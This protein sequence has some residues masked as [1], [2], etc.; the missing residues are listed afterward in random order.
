MTETPD[1]ADTQPIIETTP[2]GAPSL[3]AAL[4]TV[5]A[6]L[7]QLFAAVNQIGNIVNEIVNS[8]IM[9]HRCLDAH[10]AAQRARPDATAEDLPPVQIANVILNGQ[11]VCV[12][13][14]AT[15]G[16]IIPGR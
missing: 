4:A 3:E 16:L 15:S 10:I 12:N 13:H 5:P 14:I 8:R 6:A 7:V 9:C 1:A 2:N 11:G